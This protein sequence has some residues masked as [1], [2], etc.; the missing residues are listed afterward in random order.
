MKIDDFVN[1]LAKSSLN[2]YD[3]LKLANEVDEISQLID[4]KNMQDW[5][6][7]GL[8]LQKS[9]SGK[10]SLATTKAKISDYSFC[11]VD[12]ETN[13]GMTSG[14][15]IEIGAVKVINGEIVDKFES[16]VYSDFV[17]ENISQIT[18]ITAKDLEFAPSLGSVL[19]KF[20]LFLL[21][22]VFV[23]HN[24]KFDYG[25]ID[26]SMQEAGFGAVLNRKICTI[27]L[28][29]ILIQSPK[30]GLGYL[31]ELLDIKGVH[32]RALSDAL[33]AYEIFKICLD[34]LP[35]EVVSV[36]DLIFFSKNAKKMSKNIQI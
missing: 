28:A 24:V 21:D 35:S 31:K 3:F 29:R 2:Y 5:Q 12:I 32:H 16:F 19:E 26:K 14:Q 9:K 30:Y 33:A 25:F 18:G 4:I 8:N 11:V 13:G 6:I 34:R 27:D 17:P 15:I 20:R 7:L 1:L 36:E 10:I 23:A 22:S